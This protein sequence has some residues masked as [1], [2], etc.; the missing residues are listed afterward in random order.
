MGGGGCT[1]ILVVKK[2]F[3]VCLPLVKKMCVEE[4]FFDFFFLIDILKLRRQSSHER[5]TK[6]SGHYWTNL[7]GETRVRNSHRAW[8]YSGNSTRN[9]TNIPR[10]GQDQLSCHQLKIIGEQENE[11][12]FFWCRLCFIARN[13]G[14]LK[15][16]NN[17]SIP[18]PKQIVSL[19][20]PGLPACIFKYT[21]WHNA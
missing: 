18:N 12:T 11:V 9:W 7:P 6:Q 2:T 10:T 15:R 8:K 13:K 20:S 14:F 21:Y 17:S 5:W 1:Q 19:Y 16:N 4:F 3:F